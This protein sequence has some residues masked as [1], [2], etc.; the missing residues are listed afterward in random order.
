[1]CQKF[2][3]NPML[4]YHPDT[5]VFFLNFHFSSFFK[6]EI[7]NRRLFYSRDRSTS[8]FGTIICNCWMRID[9]TSAPIVLK[10]ERMVYH[11]V[12]SMS[13][14]PPIKPGN[15]LTILATIYIKTVSFLHLLFLLLNWFKLFL[16]CLKIA[17]FTVSSISAQT[18]KERI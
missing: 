16:S 9:K 7:A 2:T 5:E 8:L 18:S 11:V 14:T 3:Y 13:W 4:S 1:M 17:T 12:C 15:L 10:L 6:V